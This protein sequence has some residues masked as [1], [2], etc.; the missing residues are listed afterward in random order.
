MGV[1]G[2][3]RVG[4]SNPC[5]GISAN[6]NGTVLANEEFGDFKIG[7]KFRKLFSDKKS[8]IKAAGANMARDGG[9][10]DDVD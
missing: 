8:M 10:R 9:E 1:N 4:L 6:L 2:I 7:A 5:L 3:G